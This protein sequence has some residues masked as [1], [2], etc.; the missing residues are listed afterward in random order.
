[1]LELGTVSESH[2]RAVG[3]K[4]V[5]SGVDALLCFGEESKATVAAANSHISTN[6]YKNKNELISDLQD[7]I[8]TGDVILFKGSRGMAMESLIKEVFEK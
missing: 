7:I 5:E 3:K 6:H 2:H 1:M 8:K 4:C